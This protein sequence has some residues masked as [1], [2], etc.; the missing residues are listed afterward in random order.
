MHGVRLLMSDTLL[1]LFGAA[2]I[3]VF[4][5]LIIKKESSDIAS[6]LRISGGILLAVVCVSMLSPILSC[7]NEVSGF[8]SASEK[9]S[10]AVGVLLRAL[11]VAI[12]TQICS[13]IC[14]DC[15]EGSIAQYVEL[16]GKL[17]MLI[18]ALPLFRDIIE[19][20]T[21]VLGISEG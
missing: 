17:E 15:G 10:S 20:A 16:G 3:C 4:I 11:G 5:G 9:V 14:R 8:I 12:L 19:M 6:L 7:I 1:K 18:L 21:A 13:N 2:V